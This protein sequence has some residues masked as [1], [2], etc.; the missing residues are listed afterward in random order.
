MPAPG[1][2]V[3]HPHSQTGEI[4]AGQPRHTHH[5]TPIHYCTVLLVFWTAPPPPPPPPAHF[6]TPRKRSRADE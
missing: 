5:E 2:A 4:G 1:A 6:A 3:M